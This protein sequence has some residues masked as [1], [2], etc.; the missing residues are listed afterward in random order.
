MA[1]RNVVDEIER[2][3]SMSGMHTR[4]VHSMRFGEPP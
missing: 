2:I 1:E 3:P 4:N